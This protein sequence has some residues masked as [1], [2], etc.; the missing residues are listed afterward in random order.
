MR[1]RINGSWPASNP[2]VLLL[3]RLGNL[4][5]P[6]WHLI[7]YCGKWRRG[8]V[9][10]GS[11]FENRRIERYQGFES[12]RLRKQNPPEGV[13][14]RFGDGFGAIVRGLRRSLWRESL[15]LQHRFT[16]GNAFLAREP[17]PWHAY[18]DS[19]PTAHPLGIPSVQRTRPH[20]SLLGAG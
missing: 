7:C 5:F 6:Y 13:S 11:G 10:E 1:L 2:V 8:R 19:R 3:S 15:R 17:S 16:A 14:A 9:V 4:R 18:V 12:L 20:R